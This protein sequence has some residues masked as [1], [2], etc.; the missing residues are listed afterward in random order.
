MSEAWNV[1]SRM[2]MKF[3]KQKLKIKFKEQRF[4]FRKKSELGLNIF[5][6]EIL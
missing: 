4:Y 2:R 3:K 1:R 6:G 5:I